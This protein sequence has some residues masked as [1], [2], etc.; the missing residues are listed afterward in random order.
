MAID[1]IWHV[2]GIKITRSVFLEKM[3]SKLAKEMKDNDA[4]EYEVI[5]DATGQPLDSELFPETLIVEQ[6]T[7]DLDRE[8]SIVVG[9][10]LRTCR[11]GRSRCCGWEE[12]DDEPITSWNPEEEAEK[13]EEFLEICP[14]VLEYF[15]INE[16]I[17][18]RVYL[19]QDDCL[20][21]S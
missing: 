7:H 3:R 8:E 13:M 5:Q 1:T 12:E 17:E 9:V 16:T 14:T 2:Y 11:V 18:P 6:L 10:R 20:C 15:S 21:C 4:D 19:V